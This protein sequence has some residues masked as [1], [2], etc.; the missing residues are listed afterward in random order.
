ML[1][2]NHP[3]TPVEGSALCRRRDAGVYCAGKEIYLSLYLS[4]PRLL[5]LLQFCSVLLSFDYC[6]E[7]RMLK[8]ATAT[9]AIFHYS[10]LTV[11]HRLHPLF[12]GGQKR[13]NVS[14]QICSPYIYLLP[15]RV[16]SCQ[17]KFSQIA[18]TYWEGTLR[19]K[20]KRLLLTA[21]KILSYNSYFMRAFFLARKRSF[22]ALTLLPSFLLCSNFSTAFGS[23]V[24]ASPAG[25][26][27]STALPLLS[28]M[29][30]TLCILSRKGITQLSST[31]QTYTN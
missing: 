19:H 28:L 25:S 5:I 22:A 15:P 8:R 1:A 9:L 30:S 4:L 11:F 27:L 10:M 17:R 3:N 16:F 6:N 31:G 7:R 20:S 29:T 13:G 24:S 26:K 14:D 2:F 12:L 21:A 23:S 18:Y